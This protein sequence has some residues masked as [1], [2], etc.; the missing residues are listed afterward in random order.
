MQT[1]I[2]AKLHDLPVRS[3]EN[4]GMSRSH[5]LRASTEKR[6]GHAISVPGFYVWDEHRR[7]AEQWAA[8]LLEVA[9][10]APTDVV[11]DGV[12]PGRSRSAVG[13]S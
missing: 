12:D 3:H 4:D 11:A 1:E 5:G 9:S 13:S 7:D 6:A 10:C 2:Y 8:T